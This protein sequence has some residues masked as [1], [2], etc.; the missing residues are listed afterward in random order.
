M[1]NSPTVDI[2]IIGRNAAR[3]LRNNFSGKPDLLC[4]NKWIYCDSASTDN[5]LEVARELGLITVSIESASRLSPALGRYVGSRISTA[6]YILFLDSDMQ[7]QGFDTLEETINDLWKLQQKGKK[8]AGFTG[9]TIDVY[10]NGQIHHRSVK[11]YG[12][13]SVRHFGGLLLI[14]REILESVGHWD[15]RVNGNEETELHARLLKNGYSIVYDSRISCHHHTE[16][17]NPLSYLWAVYWPWSPHSQFFGAP[18]LAFKASRHNHSVRRFLI[19]NPEPPVSLAIILIL[20][21]TS[22]TGHWISAT[23]LFLAFSVWI[24]K[25]RSWR[26]LLVCPGLAVQW[27]W[28]L[29]IPLSVTFRL[30]PEVKSDPKIND[31]HQ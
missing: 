4:I 3:V 25:L 26:Y 5:S 1:E 28:G 24:I 9:Q 13:N 18:G 7:F 11:R 29:F 22:F 16:K 20:L 23:S 27:I 10:G 14:S 31:I 8:V 21:G 15:Y 19:L 2:V 30:R 6:H 17:P 12:I